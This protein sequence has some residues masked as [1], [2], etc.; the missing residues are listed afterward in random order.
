[1]FDDIV[2]ADLAKYITTVRDNRGDGLYG[3]A[4]VILKFEN[5]F[6]ASIIQGPRTY[7]GNSGLFEL[8]VVYND[9]LCYT[10]SLTSDVIGYQTQEEIIDLLFKIK[11]FDQNDLES[12]ERYELWADEFIKIFDE[13]IQG[14]DEDEYH[15]PSKDSL[16]LIWEWKECEG[17]FKRVLKNYIFK[18]SEA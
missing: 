4:Q 8:A 6:G 10:T 16:Y 7:G 14:L 3:N 9:D 5:N 11:N 15:R 13:E 2:P 12:P 17:D 18:K 1:M